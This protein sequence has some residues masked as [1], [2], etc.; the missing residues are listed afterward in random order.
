MASSTS[1]VS[2][3][4][5]V[6]RALDLLRLLALHEGSGLTL[7][8]LISHSGLE[9]STVHRLA[10]CLVEENFARRDP[11][12]RRYHLGVD[13]MYIGFS[14][15]HRTPIVETLRPLVK[16]L[17]RLTGDTVFVVIQ[18]GDYALCL[19]RE[20][21]DFPVRIFTIDEGEKRLMGMGAGG[22][23][24]LAKYSDDEVAQTHARHAACYERNG[25]GLEEL[26]RRLRR[27]RD[28]G[29]S[30]IVDGITPGISGV[31]Y[32]FPMSRVARAAISFGAISTRLDAA[33]RQELGALLVA[34]C[35]AWVSAQA[36]MADETAAFTP[37]A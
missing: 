11:D 22:L 33:R 27:T 37:S 4:Q 20:H 31:G 26:L 29:F 7:Q 13:A 30:E 8:E 12:T 3:A 18:Q 10:S 5:S 34:E 16:K 23:A 1:A 35:D 32:C 14:S 15:M 2:G 25:L 17:T 28:Q 21:G 6:R 9:R 19:M 36:S 24:M